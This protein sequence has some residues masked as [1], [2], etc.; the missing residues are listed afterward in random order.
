MIQFGLVPEA[1]LRPWQAPAAATDWPCRRPQERAS[2]RPA[3]RP[4]RRADRAAR[5]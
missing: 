1:P 4:G 5:L 3:K 2:R